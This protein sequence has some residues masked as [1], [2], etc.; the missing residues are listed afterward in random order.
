MGLLPFTVGGGWRVEWAQ[1]HQHKN[2]NS[3]I[4]NFKPW[5][6]QCCAPHP[7]GFSQP[8]APSSCLQ[9]PPPDWE[10]SRSSAHSHMFL[11]RAQGLCSPSQQDFSFNQSET[12][13]WSQRPRKPW[14]KHNCFSQHLPTLLHPVCSLHP[15]L[16]LRQPSPTGQIVTG[17]SWAD[18]V[19]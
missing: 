19:P 9:S 15:Q 16:V 11:P 14:R 17:Q 12:A 1:T 2:C 10:S 8:P 5:R 4:H 6:S 18:S 3:R 7:Q 13:S